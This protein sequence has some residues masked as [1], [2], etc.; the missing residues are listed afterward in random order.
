MRNSVIK[1]IMFSMAVALFITGCGNT[2]KEKYDGFGNTISNI[3]NS[4][5]ACEGTDKIFFSAGNNIIFT[6]DKETLEIN[7]LCD[8]PECR[9]ILNDF[10]C[11]SARFVKNMQC[12]ND[13]LYYADIPFQGY[14]K[15]DGE[16]CNEIIH[17]GDRNLNGDALLYDGKIYYTKSDTSFSDNDRYVQDIYYRDVQ[18]KKETKIVCGEHIMNMVPQKELIYVLTDEYILYSVDYDGNKKTLNNK[19]VSQII[20]EENEIYYIVQGEGLFRADRN[21]TNEKMLCEEA[22][23]FSMNDEY[24]YI[25]IDGLEKSGFYIMKKGESQVEISEDLMRVYTFSDFDKVMATNISEK[26]DSIYIM[27]KDGSDFKEIPLPQMQED[28]D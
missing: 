7:T 6:M 27:N 21:G 5:S 8:R 15:N 26:K 18:G 12:Y 19:K 16:T 14:Y 11:S 17:T 3:A 28:Y 10:Y 25:N 9:H 1:Q 20:P 22:D 4:A 2:K 24:F 23:S 13:M